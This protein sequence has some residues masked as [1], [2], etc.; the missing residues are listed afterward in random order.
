MPMPTNSVAEQ[1]ISMMQRA[2]LPTSEFSAT[3]RE[4][5]H[6]FWENQEKILNN[7]QAFSN[8]WFERRHIGTNS[9]S[10]AADRMCNPQTIVDLMEA[11]Q[12]WARG[13]IERMMADGVAWQQQIITAS[14]SFT[15]PPLAP[16]DEKASEQARSE[17]KPSARA[18][19]A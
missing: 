14:S 15:S 8:S 17:T 2:F 16:S 5:S 6:R 13:A 18:K 4:N 7:M 10:K 19:T 3:F 11:Y 12:D 9:A 1:W